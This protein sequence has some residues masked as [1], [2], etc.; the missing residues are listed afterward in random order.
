MENIDPQEITFGEFIAIQRGH[1]LP[2]KDR[3]DGD[4]PVAGSSRVVGFHNEARG[5]VP[6]IT[7][8][9][10][11]SIGD[12]NLYNSDY[13]PLNTVLYVT[14]FKGNDEKFTYYF[15]KNFD[16]SSFNSGSVQPSL[17]RNFLNPA[18]VRIPD[19]VDQKAIAHIL[20]TLDDKIELNRKMNETL[21]ETAKAIFKSWFVD[22]DPVRAKMQG[23]PTGLPDDI[24]ALFPDRLVDSEIGEIPKGWSVPELSE[25]AD[26]LMGQ[27]PPGETYNDDGIGMPF[28]QGSTDFGFRYPSIR[29]YCSSPKREARVNDTLLSV[30]APVG[31][32]NRAAEQCCIGRGVASVR[33]KDGLESWVYYLCGNLQAY[34]NTFNS[35]GTVFGSV[36]G[37]DLKAM[38][39]V[40]PPTQ[41]SECFENLASKIDQSIKL[42]TDEID[43]LT[44]LRDTL[45]P[46]LICGE[47]QIPDAETFLKEAGI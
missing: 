16:F 31:E 40:G 33:S 38:K 10:S 18:P 27:S 26:I 17:N 14:D 9:R 36:S 37:K 13:F 39:V 34:F 3:V 28:Y 21:E 45:L 6:G 46:K 32:L 7:I 19:I 5:T 4:I 25:L 15:L 22:F 11:G 35:E 12:V 30:R 23:R 29:K 1:D 42:K 8:G 2:A 44:D 43:V 20:G 41:V 47:L 24:A